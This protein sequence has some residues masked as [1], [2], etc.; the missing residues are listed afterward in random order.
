MD[1]KKFTALEFAIKAAC[2]TEQNEAGFV[3]TNPEK[4]IEAAKKIEEYLK[5]IENNV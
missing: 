3:I 4:L 5:G 1:D 2:G